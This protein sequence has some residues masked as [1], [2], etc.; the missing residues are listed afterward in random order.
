MKIHL[1]WSLVVLMAVALAAV[2]C[3]APYVGPVAEEEQTDLYNVVI[4]AGIY[5]QSPFDTLR[6]RAVQDIQELCTHIG[7]AVFSA[8]EKVKGVNQ[9]STSADFGSASF[10]LPQGEYQLVI[11]AHNCNGT[12]T[13]SSPQK[14]TFPS[15]VVSDTFYYYGTFTV[16][17]GQTELNLQLTRAVAMVRVNITDDMPSAVRQMKFYYTGGSSTFSAETG[18]GCVNSKQTVKMDVTTA[19]QGKPTTWELYTLPHATTGALKLTISALDAADNIL[20]EKELTDVPVTVNAIT[21]Y[22][23]TLFGTAP[24]EADSKTFRLTADGAWD[25]GSSHSF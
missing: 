25:E 18:F 2:G 13:I 11:I 12:A 14:I 19:M 21:T 8:D 20:Y 5:D 16:G 15:N 4:R 1:P 9:V 17:D 6:S 10:T 23:G 24:Q 22:S 3:E 7:F